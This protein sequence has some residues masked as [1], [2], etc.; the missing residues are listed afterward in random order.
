MDLFE[1]LEAKVKIDMRMNSLT[2][3]D[4]LFQLFSQSV[5]LFFFDWE[6]GYKQF[7]LERSP[8]RS[9][10]N[11]YFHLRLEPSAQRTQKSRTVYDIMTF[12]S[13]AGGLYGSLVI[14]GFVYQSLFGDAVRSAWLLETLY[15]VSNVSGLVEETQDA[16]KVSLRD[17]RHNW[18]KTLSRYRL[19][20]RD[21]ILSLICCLCLKNRTRTGILEAKL[22][23]RVD[24]HLDIAR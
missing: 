22:H 19:T 9:R 12:L 1:D 24:R 20:L 23:A 17:K 15:L 3:N 10:A 7:Y 2:L 11:N 13:D 5:T 8:E 14:L 18:W 6:R 16:K 21:R 4:S